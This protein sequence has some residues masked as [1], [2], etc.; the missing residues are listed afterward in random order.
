MP[1]LAL[2]DKWL[3]FGPDE[4]SAALEFIRRVFSHRGI[5]AWAPD[6]ALPPFALIAEGEPFTLLAGALTGVDGPRAARTRAMAS[7]MALERRVRAGER[8]LG[9]VIVPVPD[10]LAALAPLLPP[11]H[12]LLLPAGFSS[13]FGLGAGREVC[14]RDSASRSA[15]LAERATEIEQL[16]GEPMRGDLPDDISV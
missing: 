8:E 16:L 3:E 15:T 12:R 10:A 6:P 11:L 4:D 9:V 14:M 2:L 13:A 1:F 5:D 7:L